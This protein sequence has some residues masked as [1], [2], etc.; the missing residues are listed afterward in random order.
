[1]VSST[2]CGDAGTAT[3]P[4]VVVGNGG[5]AQMTI[6]NGASVSLLGAG[7]RMPA[8]PH[9]WVVVEAARTL[10]VPPRELAFVGDTA[11]DV[12]AAKAAWVTING[13]HALGDYSGHQGPEGQ[14]AQNHRIDG[15]AHQIQ[16]NKR[17]D[18]R[19][20]NREEDSEGGSHAPEENQN[21]QACKR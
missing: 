11:V 14:A 19:N 17:R 16:D 8:K 21:H 7:E 6:S 15:A 12:A 5:N 18:C 4:Y 13:W 1:M 10:G 2:S 20:R 9:P 3:S